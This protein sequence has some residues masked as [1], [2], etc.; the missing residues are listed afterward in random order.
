MI[1]L[2][3]HMVDLYGDDLESHMVE[4]NDAIVK[5]NVEPRNPP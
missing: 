4:V 5:R 1:D 3:N 2:K